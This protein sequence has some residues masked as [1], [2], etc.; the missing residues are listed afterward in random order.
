[1]VRKAGLVICAALIV[2][3]ATLLVANV[4]PKNFKVI[5]VVPSNINRAGVEEPQDACQFHHP[6]VP[7]KAYRR[8]D[9]GRC[10]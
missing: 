10:F 6:M 3:V 7:S 2:A 1:M 8:A 9:S 5:A 4:P